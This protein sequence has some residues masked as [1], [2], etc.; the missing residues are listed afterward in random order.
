MTDL[1]LSSRTI[2]AMV[3]VV[4]ACLL[5]LAL[6]GNGEPALPHCRANASVP[7]RCQP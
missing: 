5:T 2:V 3:A 6:M 4:C 1:P 7:I